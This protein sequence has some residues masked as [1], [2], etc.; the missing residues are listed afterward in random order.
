MTL[1]YQEF[2]PCYEQLP[3]FHRPNTWGD[4]FMTGSDRWGVLYIRRGENFSRVRNRRGR[5]LRVKIRHGGISPKKIP[6]AGGDLGGRTYNGTP[7]LTVPCPSMTL[8]TGCQPNISQ[9]HSAPAK[10]DPNHIHPHSGYTSP[11]SGNVLNFS[12]GHRGD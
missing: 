1:H 8:D 9:R 6:P 3:R 7:A 10:R 2:A 11:Q 4:F 12:R 5:H